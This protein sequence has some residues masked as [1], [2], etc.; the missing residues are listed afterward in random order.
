MLIINCY[1]I[2][3]VTVVYKCLLVSWFFVIQTSTA[4]DQIWTLSCNRRHYALVTCKL[5][6]ITDTDVHIH[7]YPVGYV[8]FVWSAL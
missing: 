5:L 1:K 8:L 4:Y 3:V 7:T 6:F 2:K